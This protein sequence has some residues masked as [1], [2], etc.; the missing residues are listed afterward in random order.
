MEGRIEINEA[1]DGFEY[2][3]SKDGDDDSLLGVWEDC[4]LLLMA[5]G[6]MKA[7]VYSS[8]VG[9]CVFPK[10]ELAASDIWVRSKES[11][12]D[13]PVYTYLTLST[14]VHSLYENRN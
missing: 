11:D 1:K 7:C 5:R 10:L 2:D 3:V 8:C 14:S 6:T 4:D 9:V 13:E 12:F